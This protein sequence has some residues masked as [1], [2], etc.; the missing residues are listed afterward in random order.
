[1]EIKVTAKH[2]S[3]GVR[4]SPCNCPVALALK[5]QMHKVVNVDSMSMMYASISRESTSGWRQAD[6]PRKVR[7]FILRYDYGKTVKPF[8]FDINFRYTYP[9]LRPSN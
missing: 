9:R 7:G 8:S 3:K 1:M 2:I 6:T 4:L 5:E